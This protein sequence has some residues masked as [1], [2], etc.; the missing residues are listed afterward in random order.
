MLIFSQALGENVCRL[1][2]GLHNLQPHL[3]VQEPPH[4]V[5]LWPDVLCQAMKTSILCKLHS[6]LIVTKNHSWLLL[7]HSVL[8]Q[9]TPQPHHLLSPMMKDH[10]LSLTRGQPDLVLLLAAPTHCT[11]SK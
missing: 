7:A 9:Q 4:P 2:M 5:P 3:L 1:L 8:L 6:R 11:T 10:V